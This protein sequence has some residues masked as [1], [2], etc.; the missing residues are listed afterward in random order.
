MSKEK[1]PKPTEGELELLQILWKQG[2]SMVRNIHNALEK[3]RTVGYTTTLKVLQKM[4]AKGLVRRDET[5][6]RHVYVPVLEAKQTQRQLANDLAK[7]G[8]GGSTARLVV[9]ALSA[10]RATKEELAEIRRLL[11]EMEGK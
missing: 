6:S 8:F 2:P 11:D 4:M 3:D 1:L 10:K 5:A 9:A 7:R